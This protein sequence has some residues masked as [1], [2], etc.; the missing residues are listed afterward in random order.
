MVFFYKKTLLPPGPSLPG[1]WSLMGT[2]DHVQSLSESTLMDAGLWHGP[3]TGLGPGP[4]FGPGGWSDH[5]VLHAFCFWV[6][7]CIL[8]YWRQTRF[9]ATVTVPCVRDNCGLCFPW[10][11]TIC[12]IV[13]R[14]LLFIYC[15][16][17]VL[18]RCVRGGVSVAV[19]VSA[20]S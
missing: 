5:G 15:G 16:W 20:C 2:G 6:V 18:F 11:C 4:C 12:M 17:R 13:E 19:C 3:R 8:L 7:L 14:D 9:W 1:L 10:R